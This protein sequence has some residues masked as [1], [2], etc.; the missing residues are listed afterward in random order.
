MTWLKYLILSKVRLGISW[1]DIILLYTMRFMV[2]TGR[3]LTLWSITIPLVCPILLIKIPLIKCEPCSSQTSL[4]SLEK[5][6]DRI[7]R[8]TGFS[9]ISFSRPGRVGCV[10]LFRNS[11]MRNTKEAARI[12]HHINCT[13]RSGRMSG[14]RARRR[15]RMHS[16]IV[17]CQVKAHTLGSATNSSLSRINLF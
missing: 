11:E 17:T 4:P 9:L 16:L 1:L 10:W 5:C 8:S 2:L 7:K 3:L 12:N 6:S 14:L 15:I 13:V